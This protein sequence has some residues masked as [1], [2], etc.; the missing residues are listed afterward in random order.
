MSNKS[1]IAILGLPAR[2]KPRGTT[3]A[4][5]TIVLALLL[6]LLR[7]LAAAQAEHG[8]VTMTSPT[9]GQ[10]VTYYTSSTTL[11][12]TCTTTH[13]PQSDGAYGA[14]IVFAVRPY[15]TGGFDFNQGYAGSSPYTATRTMAQWGITGSGSYE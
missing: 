9:S 7:P 6:P 3:V 12:I 13:T 14:G 11:S 4:A 5:L 8:S 15:N 1:T 10:S 2:V